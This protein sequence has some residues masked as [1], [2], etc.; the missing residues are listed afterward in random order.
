MLNPGTYQRFMI[1]LEVNH[2]HSS[3]LFSLKAYVR[4]PFE[5]GTNSMSQISIFCSRLGFG[6]LFQIRLKPLALLIFQ[7]LL[8]LCTWDDAVGSYRRRY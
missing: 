3:G 6:C 7:E 5:F 4:V 2:L 8:I 1:V